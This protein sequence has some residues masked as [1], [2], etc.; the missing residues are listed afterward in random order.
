MAWFTPSTIHAGLSPKEVSEFKEVVANVT[1]YRDEIRDPVTAENFNKHK[2]AR[3]AL[4]SHLIDLGNAYFLGHGVNKSDVDAFKS[5]RESAELGSNIALFN[6]GHCY[7]DGIG[8]AKDQTEAYGY[9]LLCAYDLNKY[10]EDEIKTPSYDQLDRWRRDAKQTKNSVLEKLCKDGFN[11]SFNYSATDEAKANA[12]ILEKSIAA[13]DQAKGLKRAQVIQE[14]L[15]QA[16]SK[17]RGAKKDALLLQ[18]KEFEEL[19]QRAAAGDIQAQGE[20]AQYF[21]I[22]YYKDL[23]FPRDGIEAN[24]WYRAAAEGGNV[25]AQMWLCWSYFRDKKTDE[26]LRWLRKASVQGSSEAH[27][28]LA[29]CYLEGTGVPKSNI[30]AYAYLNISN[31]IG[32]D[33]SPGLTELELKMSP[34]EKRLGLQ[35]TKELHIEIDGR[36]KHSP[37]TQIL[38]GLALQRGNKPDQYGLGSFFQVGPVDYAEAVRWFRKAAEQGDPDG[39]YY[40]GR[41]YDSGKGVSEDKVQAVKW[42]R[43]A[44]EKGVAIAQY[45]L[46]HAYETG[47]G[48]A[49]D[50]IE[51]YA[52]FNLA[53]A[54]EKGARE[55]IAKME[56]TMQP[57][58]RLLGQQRTRELRKEIEGKIESLEEL[59]KAVEKE[60]QLKGI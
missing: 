45:M 28:L 2:W 4:G 55:R 52:Y 8:V 37:N 30:D 43:K 20:I 16:S 14:A 12:A 42:Y 48:V 36:I 32:E 1:K 57:N 9:W 24:K 15:D 33:R 47:E 11:K 38:I 6:L 35:R 44:A 22:G 10:Q 26:G 53:G 39:E 41:A 58:V 17:F 21:L 19:R 60:K 34:E 59:R 29:K 40:V 27:E 5:W 13:D 46:G 3:L 25:K 56:E 23:K 7:Y 49:K 50:E 51:A 54:T 18:K 31:F